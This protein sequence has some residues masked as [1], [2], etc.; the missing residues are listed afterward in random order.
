MKKIIGNIRVKGDVVL[1]VNRKSV[2]PNTMCLAL[3]FLALP[4]IES[5]SM[6]RVCN[7]IT[8]A[9][10]VSLIRCPLCCKK[11]DSSDLREPHQC[12]YDKCLIC[13][14]KVHV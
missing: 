13:H 4:V 11:L 2:A 14:G 10:F 9:I 8:R 3:L 7:G 5:S 1:P 6:R 12:H